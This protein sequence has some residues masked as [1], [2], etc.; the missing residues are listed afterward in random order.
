MGLTDILLKYA[1]EDDCE[2]AKDKGEEDG[3]ADDKV[4]DAEDDDK[5][6]QRHQNTVSMQP[7]S[8]DQSNKASD[9]YQLHTFY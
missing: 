6:F 8:A 9:L 1:G 3:D 5:R 7:T 2:D 4:E